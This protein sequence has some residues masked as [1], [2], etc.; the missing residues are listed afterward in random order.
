[1]SIKEIKEKILSDAQSRVDEM[2]LTAET[3]AKEILFKGKK[4]AER[5]KKEILSNHQQEGLLKKNKILTDANLN[6]K[7][8]LLQ[9][10]QVIIESVFS[11]ALQKIITMDDQKYR[12]YIEKLLLDNIEDGSEIISISEGDKQRIDVEFIEKM[13]KKLKSNGKK[14]DLRLADS[15]AKIKGGVIISSGNIKKNISLE[16][17]ILKAKEKYEMEINKQLFE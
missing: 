4:E 15:F 13:N 8:I 6:A 10:K 7:K 5:L 3:K 2:I 11:K 14:G 17:L 12:H 16:F 1:M 9:E